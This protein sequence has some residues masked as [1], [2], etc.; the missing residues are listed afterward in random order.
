MFDTDHTLAV[1]PYLESYARLTRTGLTTALA[2][3]LIALT[4][5]FA[6]HSFAADAEARI[7]ALV[8]AEVGG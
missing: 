5:A 6:P 7:S 1:R 2:G 8:E 3:A 4:T